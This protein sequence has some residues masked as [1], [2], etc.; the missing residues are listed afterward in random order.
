[1]I[2]GFDMLRLF[3]VRILNKKNPF[4]SD[5]DHLHHWLIKKFS[6]SMSLFVYFT[7]VTIPLFLYNFFNIPALLII[8]ISVT[9]YIILLI[10]LKK[11]T[12]H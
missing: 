5:L 12:Q 4:T 11:S 8:L 6:L 10:F 3:I 2:P 1:M 9:F 7:S